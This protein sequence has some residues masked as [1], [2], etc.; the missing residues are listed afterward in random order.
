[1]TF[2]QRVTIYCAVDRHEAVEAVKFDFWWG[3][4]FKSPDVKSSTR[5]YA[6]SKLSLTDFIKSRCGDPYAHNDLFNTVTYRHISLGKG[7]NVFI[8][9][10]P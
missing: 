2:E 4:N 3:K 9:C 10:L 8:R 1:M 5:E 6:Q 7:R